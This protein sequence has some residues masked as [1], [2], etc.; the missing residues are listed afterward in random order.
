MANIVVKGIFMKEK[1][2]LISHN[3]KFLLP[4]AESSFINLCGSSDEDG[5]SFPNVIVPIF[6]NS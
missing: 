3:S 1:P 4:I 6:T 2:T 5:P